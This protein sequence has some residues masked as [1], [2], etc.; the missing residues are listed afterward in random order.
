MV[1]DSSIVFRRSIIAVSTRSRPGTSAARFTRPVAARVRASSGETSGWASRSAAMSSGT[2]PGSSRATI[3]SL[4]AGLAQCGDGVFVQHRSLA[5]HPLADALRV[6]HDGAAGFVQRDRAELHAACGCFCGTGAP[7]RTATSLGDDRQRDLR[8]G[9]RLDV[10][11]DRSLDAR[12][13]RLAV[14]EFAQ[15]L[16]P[17]GVRA[18]RAERADVERRRLQRT[19]QRRIVQLR[20]VRQRHDRGAAVGL[21]LIHRLVRPGGGDGDVRESVRPRRTTGADPPR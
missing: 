15:P 17:R 5:D 4:A 1:S 18:P 14:A 8:R 7:R 16:Q 10:E 19:V 3:T 12:Q 13:R 6:R 2:S 20:I 21:Q 11:A 9:H